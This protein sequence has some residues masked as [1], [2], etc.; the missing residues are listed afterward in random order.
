MSNPFPAMPSNLVKT[1]DD[2]G[3]ASKK[4]A[5]VS[6]GLHKELLHKDASSLFSSSFEKDPHLVEVG[7][8]LL[9]INMM[10]GW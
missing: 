3:F 9:T 8:A 5:E 4:L 1:K 7:S 2:S 6:K 10:T